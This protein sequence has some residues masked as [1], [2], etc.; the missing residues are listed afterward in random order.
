MGDNLAIFKK[1]FAELSM[2]DYEGGVHIATMD[3]SDGITGYHSVSISPSYI[4]PTE[5]TSFR[6]ESEK[7]DGI[8][9]RIFPPEPHRYGGH[10]YV[11]T[12]SEGSIYS[13]TSYWRGRPMLIIYTL[14]EK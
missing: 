14:G 7:I 3:V 10:P 11:C 1:D 2:E 9:N 6:I 12:G 4:N 5:K 13:N 8:E